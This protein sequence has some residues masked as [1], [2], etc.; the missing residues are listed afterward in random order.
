[1]ECKG[2][3]KRIYNFNGFSIYIIILYNF[4]GQIKNDIKFQEIYLFLE[5]HLKNNHINQSLKF[6]STFKFLN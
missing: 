5:E 3:S 1:M 4:N 2:N 6:Y